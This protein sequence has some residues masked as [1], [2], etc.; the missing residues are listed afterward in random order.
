MPDEAADFRRRQHAEPHPGLRGAQGHGQGAEVAEDQPPPADLALGRDRRVIVHVDIDCFYAQAEEVRDPSL[1]SKPL[2][3]TQKYLVVTCN[4]VARGYG[5]TKLMGI[6]EAKRRCPVLV[7]VS[8]EDLTPYRR[9]SKEIGSVLR[10]FAPVQRLGLDESW[11]DVSALVA[12][13]LGRGAADTEFCGHVYDPGGAMRA[14]SRHRP[15][16]L[17]MVP[18]AGPGEGPGR[19][20]GEAGSGPCRFAV[21][22]AVA[23]EIRRALRRETGFTASVGVSYW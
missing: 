1:R 11:L 17:R 6:E 9:A 20:K 4:Y 8:G 12:A 15:Q 18:G 19:R 22:S 13:R 2:G 16:D 23:E 21:G 10:R 7:L 3:V 14:A 5:I